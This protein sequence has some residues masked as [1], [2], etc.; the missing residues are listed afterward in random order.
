VATLMT[1]LLIVL[2]FSVPAAIASRRIRERWLAEDQI[3]HLALH[4][5]PTGPPRTRDHRGHHPADTEA[6]LDT[7]SA[8]TSSASRLPWTISAP[9]IRASPISPASR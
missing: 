6:V 2:G 3:R 8:S 9:A 5:S 1:S 7:C 4:E